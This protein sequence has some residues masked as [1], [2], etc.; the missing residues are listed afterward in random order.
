MYYVL[1]C[2]PFVNEKGEALLEIHNC[3]RAGNVRN[4]GDGKAPKSD[5]EVP[6]PL[7]IEFEAFRGY[8]GSPRELVDVCIPIMSARLASALK[9]AGVD[10][11]VFYPARLKNKAT[12][13]VYDYFAFK[14]V[15]LVAAADMSKSQWSSYDGTTVGDTSFTT[16][17]LDENKA[18]GLLMFRLAENFSALVV[19]E[20]VRDRVFASGIDTL[21]FVKP[22][23]WVHL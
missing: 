18:G 8:A 7:D 19:H 1:R 11:V 3:F 13:Q 23:D 10:N 12:G 21:L 20:R 9:E 17:V 15:G 2:P 6:T 22:E 14:V 5:T 4:W 16:L